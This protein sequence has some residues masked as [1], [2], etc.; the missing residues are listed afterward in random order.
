[1]GTWT[2]KLNNK[3]GSFKFIYVKL[4]PDE[5]PPTRRKRTNSKIGGNKSKPKSLEEVLD[6]IGLNVGLF[7]TL[8]VVLLCC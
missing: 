3:V 8:C 4:L 7:F 5:L 1:M 2:G 6:T